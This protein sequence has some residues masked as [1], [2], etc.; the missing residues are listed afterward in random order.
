MEERFTREVR[1][2]IKR[3]LGLPQDMALLP[4]VPELAPRLQAL[5]ALGLYLHIP[6]CRH[7][8]LYCPYHKELYKTEVAA[9]YARAVRREIDLYA[10]MVGQAPVTSFYIGGGTPTTMLNDG[11]PDI[12][13][14]VRR[15]FNLQCDIHM[16]SHPTDLSR[17]N[18]AAIYDLGVRHLS[19]GVEALQDR[20]LNMLRRGYTAAQAEQAVRRALE[21]GFRC[22]NADLIFAL[23]E[24]TEAEVRHAAH[25][26]VELGV[27]QVAAYPLFTFPYTR[28]RDLADGVG[29]ASLWTKRSMMRALEETFRQA[30]YERT[31]VWAFTRRGVPRYCSVTVP[32]YLGL[33]A[34]AASYLDDIFYLNTFQV[35]AY[36]DTLEAG[37]LPVALSLELSP[38]MQRAGW[39]Y[40]RVYETR[41]LKES[42]QR[43]FG[44]RFDQV[45]GRWTQWLGRLR[46]LEDLG[47]EIR[48]TD[49]GAFW[50]HALQDCF[51]IDYVGRLWGLSRSDPWPGRIAL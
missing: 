38:A 17:E 23:P 34:S 42:F 47:E 27:D 5:N 51:S 3:L 45:Y 29:E 9:R 21:G 25:L 31:S 41:F 28:W 4:K 32:L 8:C 2:Q 36:M 15:S 43:R 13:E 7:I 49:A 24:Q 44:E 30:G 39:L 19:T 22:V 18:L 48:L 20:H 14:H 6:F 37:R 1:G 50:L 35:A 46:L 11:L 12:I 26:L 33:G 16:E 40:W 10:T